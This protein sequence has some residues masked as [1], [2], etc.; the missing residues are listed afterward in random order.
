MTTPDA[1][2]FD[3]GQPVTLTEIA[4]ALE[5]VAQ[6]G[7]SWLAALPLE[8][9]FA[10]P[11]GRWSPV[12][13]VRHL[14]K[15]TWPVALG[16]RLP[17]AVLRAVYGAPRH[18]SR[19]FDVLRDE[20]RRRLAAGGQAGRFAPSAEPPPRDAERRRRQVLAA[21]R[22]A[23]D[24]AVRAIKGLDERA[25]E[26]ARMPHPLLGGLTLREMAAFTLYHTSHHLELARTR[27]PAQTPPTAGV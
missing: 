11:A 20:Y 10:R 26:R 12:E 22:R 27:L 21:W 13:H 5:R 3:P 8:S 23:I 24:A 15:S 2:S 19:A 14:R 16:L 9:F 7:E 1:R 6:A 17:G 18:P 25:A 4:Q